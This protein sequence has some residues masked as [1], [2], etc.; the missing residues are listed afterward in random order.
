MIMGRDKRA[1]LVDGQCMDTRTL[2]D[3]HWAS[4]HG[5]LDIGQTVCPMSVTFIDRW[6]RQDG[7]DGRADMD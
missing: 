3:G 2:I 5:Q 6:S 7:I 1:W 4:G